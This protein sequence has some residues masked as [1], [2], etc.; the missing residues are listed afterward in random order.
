MRNGSFVKWS[1]R[2]EGADATTATRSHAGIQGMPEIVA[3]RTMAPIQTVAKS[4]IISAKI[5]RSVYESD[6]DRAVRYCTVPSDDVVRSVAP[7]CKSAL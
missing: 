1:S 7:R 5:I 4:V 3:L 2:I 6:C